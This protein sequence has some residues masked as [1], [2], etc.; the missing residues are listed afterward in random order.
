MDTLKEI[1]DKTLK[2]IK[3]KMREETFK[4]L[5]AEET[6]AP[7]L[8]RIENGKAIVGLQHNFFSDFFKKNKM[9]ILISD[10]ISSVVGKR[11]EVEFKVHEGKKVVPRLPEKDD[12]KKETSSSF[13]K[14]FTFDNFVVGEGNRLAYSAAFAVSEK[15]GEI[16]NPLFIYGGVGLGKTHLLGAI[17]NHIKK[18]RPDIKVMYVT[19]EKFLDD[20]IDA[21]QKRQQLI[22]KRK[23]RKNDILLIDDV[24][25]VKDRSG[26]QEEL[27]HIFNEFHSVGKQIVFTSDRPPVEIPNLTERIRSRFLAGLVCDIQPPDFETR[28][29]ILKKKCELFKVKVDD[30]ILKKIAERVKGNVRLLECAL[31]KIKAI[32][33]HI[34]RTITEEILDLILKDIAPGRKTVSPERIIEEVS[35]FYRIPVTDIKSR[36]RNQIV[37]QARQIA[38]YLMRELLELSFPV[39]GRIIG[40]DH[41]TIIHDYKKIEKLK[42]EDPDVKEVLKLLK[43]KLGYEQEKF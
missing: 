31:Q 13:L 24:H 14:R 17:Y 42:E 28:V 22:F 40:R 6:I 43:E 4:S 16:Y 9:D 30:N 23:Y 36:K 35:K 41:S 29:A 38:V 3:E 33:S 39:I 37:S 7:V 1:W 26:L 18:N 8:L 25:L 34:G 32:Q 11:L 20:L 12:G 21:I 10:A 27:F 5:F 2:V 19:C 15:P